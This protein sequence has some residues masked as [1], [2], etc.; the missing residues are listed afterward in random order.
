MAESRNAG[1]RCVTLDATLL[2]GQLEQDSGLKELLPQLQ[3]THPH[4]FS[5]TAVFVPKS[6][7]EAIQASISAIE[8]VIAFPQYHSEVL[9]GAPG[10][11]SSLFLTRN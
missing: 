6:V 7:A 8:R 9:S 11:S 10:Y 1:C 3:A 2:R 5:S 4:L